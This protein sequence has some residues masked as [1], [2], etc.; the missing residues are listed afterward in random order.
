MC[1][2]QYWQHRSKSYVDLK[3]IAQR[4]RSGGTA[5]QELNDSFHDVADTQSESHTERR[6]AMQGLLPNSIQLEAGLV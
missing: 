6:R 2:K 1:W 3:A 4:R 5:H